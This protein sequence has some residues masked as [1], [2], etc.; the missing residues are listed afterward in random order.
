MRGSRGSLGPAAQVGKPDLAVPNISLDTESSVYDDS[1]S[2]NPHRSH[3]F[4]DLEESKPQSLNQE[5]RLCS[6][7]LPD[8]STTDSGV[9]AR[10]LIAES[11]NPRSDE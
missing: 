9:L 3:V 11:R 2:M 4:G 10:M 5:L 1:G 7:S 6:I 8:I